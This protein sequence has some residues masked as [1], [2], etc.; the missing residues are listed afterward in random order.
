MPKVVINI[1]VDKDL[2]KSMGCTVSADPFYS[3]SNMAAINEAAEQI[4]QD[5]IVVKTLEELEALTNE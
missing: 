4:K 2:K 1:R 3:E 5:R